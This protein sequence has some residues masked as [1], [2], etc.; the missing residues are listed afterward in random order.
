MEERINEGTE[1]G[2]NGQDN[3]KVNAQGVT[4]D[5]SGRGPVD[6]GCVPPRI[7]PPTAPPVAATPEEV[8]GVF[9]ADQLKAVLDGLGADGVRLFALYAEATGRVD[10]LLEPVPDIEGAG[11]HHV[12]YQEGAMVRELMHQTASGSRLTDAELEAQW[13]K[14]V[15]Y[16]L[17]T[18]TGSQRWALMDRGEATGFILFCR[19]LQEEPKR[20]D[21]GELTKRFLRQ[22]QIYEVPLGCSDP[23]TKV[24]NRSGAEVDGI[25]TVS[26]SFRSYAEAIG[27][28]LV[29]AST[30]R[31]GGVVE[32]VH[33]EDSLAE[34]VCKV[35][36]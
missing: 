19:P 6:P 28:C 7:A 9:P 31:P 4:P 16:L 15:S 24:V 22:V 21:A 1:V 18:T 2:A 30:K 34:F 11:R 33:C 20:D 23:E 13:P 17:D 36:R 29:W 26:H 35:R 3:P 12:T 10:P 25:A 8:H 5:D 32:L 27:G 14:L